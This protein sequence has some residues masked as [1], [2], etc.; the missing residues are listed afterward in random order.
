MP[1]RRAS[2]RQRHSKESDTYSGVRGMGRNDKSIVE[3]PV[4]CPGGVSLVKFR[5]RFQGVEIRPAFDQRP[6]KAHG[7]AGRSSSQED[8]GH[9]KAPERTFFL[10]SD[11][12][13]ATL[14]KDGSQGERKRR[15]LRDRGTTQVVAKQVTL[16]RKDIIMATYYY[17]KMGSI[18]IDSFLERRRN[19]CQEKANLKLFSA[20]RRN[21]S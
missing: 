8:R 6:G 18:L 14:N 5:G 19:E 13:I 9:P 15:A 16:V 3:L 11:P 2:R 4:S 1:S 10:T 21:A 17:C 12:D 20:E 7:L